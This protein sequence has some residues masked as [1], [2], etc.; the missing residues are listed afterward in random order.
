[1]ELETLDM[2][3]TALLANDPRLSDFDSRTALFLDTETGRA[4]AGG[5]GNSGLSCRCGL[6]RS[7]WSLP[8]PPAFR[9]EF[10]GRTGPFSPPPSENCRF[11]TLF[12]SRFNGKSFDINLLA[13]RYIRTVWTTRCP[14]CLIST[15]FTR[16]GVFSG[17]RIQQ[18]P[19]ITLEE[20]LLKFYRED[21]LPGSEVPMR[22]FNWLRSRDP[23]PLL[24][25]FRH[26]RLDITALAALTVHLAGI[27][28][29]N[30]HCS[31]YDPSDLCAAARLF[32]DRGRQLSACSLYEDASRSASRTA[33][34]EARQALSLIHKK[35]SQWEKA[36]I[37][38]ENL[39]KENP[40]DLF[41][42]EE[43]AKWR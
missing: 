31:H 17:H 41:A 29:S 43:L 40:N 24:D 33:S 20:A 36:V 5:T 26:N 32:L 42:A 10:R 27:F 28:N 16:P 9:P 7:G 4:L 37:L 21:D 30:G 12:W 11:E 25:V 15:C 23:H 8:R 34:L 35:N 18:Q 1:M 6:V 38:W 13:T 22:Y 3:A 19:L 14:P 39:L 2:E